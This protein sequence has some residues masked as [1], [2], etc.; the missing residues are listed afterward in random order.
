M[1]ADAHSAPLYFAR[2]AMMQAYK[3]HRPNQVYIIVEERV[4]RLEGEQPGM[5]ARLNDMRTDMNARLNDIRSDMNFR[6][7]IIFG[8]LIAILGVG[9]T[10]LGIGVTILLQLV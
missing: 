4:S 2:Y 9:V 6:F 7:N 5:S 1:C 10:I 8:L 3:W